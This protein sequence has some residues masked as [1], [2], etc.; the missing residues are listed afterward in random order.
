[1]KID[2]IIEWD[3]VVQRCGPVH[4]ITSDQLVYII[5]VPPFALISRLAQRLYSQHRTLVIL[6]CLLYSH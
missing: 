1:M 4:I 6:S 5:K 2:R 3:D